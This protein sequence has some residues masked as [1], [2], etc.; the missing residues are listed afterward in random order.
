MEHVIFILNWNIK[1][2][3]NIKFSVYDVFLEKP[4]SGT[5]NVK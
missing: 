1:Q 2:N 5:L 4:S 3:V